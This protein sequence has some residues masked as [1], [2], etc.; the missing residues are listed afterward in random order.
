MCRHLAYLGEPRAPWELLFGAEH[1]LLTQSYAPSDMRG[2]GTVNADGFGLGWYADEPE[3]VR[4]RRSTPLWTD[5]ALPGLSASVRPGAFL[6]AV[7]NGTTGMPVTEAAAA[8]FADG[9]WLFSLNGLVRGWPESVA[10]LAEKLPVTELLTLE[11]PTDS[12]LLWA[13]LRDRLRA[14]EDPLDAAVDLVAAVEAAAPGSRLNLLLTDG[15]VLVATAWTHSLSVLETATG[16]TVASEPV[17]DGDWKPVPER[18]AV[19]VSPGEGGFPVE[20]IPIGHHHPKS[21]TEERSASQS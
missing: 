11:A 8:P 21:S 14:G 7:R 2:G 15:K 5:E 9:P 1:S 17:G 18:H 10:S 6:A 16:V 20:L 3:P 13:L 4:Y 12:A 19:R